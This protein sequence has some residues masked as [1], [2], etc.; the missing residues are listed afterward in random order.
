MPRL[1]VVQARDRDRDKQVF[2]A[3]S[4]LDEEMRTRMPRIGLWLDTSEMTV[5]ETV[6]EILARTDEAVITD[7]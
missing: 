2:D 7:V 5:E 4:F 1:D 3:W 6:A